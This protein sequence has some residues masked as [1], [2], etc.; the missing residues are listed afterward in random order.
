VRLPV[1]IYFCHFVYRQR[2]DY[3][4]PTYQ[5]TYYVQQGGQCY[6]LR[7][8]LQLPVDQVA[9][10][11]CH[12]ADTGAQP[13]Y[14]GTLPP[15][16]PPRPYVQQQQ[17]QHHQSGLSDRGFGRENVYGAPRM[18]PQR[19]L[20][21]L[22][23]I[24]EAATAEV[25]QQQ[26]Q[27]QRAGRPALQFQRSMPG[28]STAVDPHCPCNQPGRPAAGVQQRQMSQPTGSGAASTQSSSSRG[29]VISASD[30]STVLAR[31]R[32]P[33]L[34]C[35]VGSGGPS[36]HYT[37][38]DPTEVQHL[39]QSG[40]VPGAATVPGIASGVLQSSCSG[41]VYDPT[42]YGSSFQYQSSLDDVASC[43][44]PSSAGGGVV[45]GMAGGGGPI[46]GAGVAVGGVVSG[47]VSGSS[48]QLASGHEIPLRPARETSQPRLDSAAS[49]AAGSGCSENSSW[50]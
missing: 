43:G 49:C 5:P 39:L 36:Q 44:S 46:G 14:C 34:P 28:S 38:L 35:S 7:E 31:G 15:P 11:G 10:G 1:Y 22:P 33:S 40:G 48:G 37:V 13:K 30:A 41:S 16:K 6:E 42:G 21:S 9:F 45:V 19:P 8:E 27:Q 20:P 17:P 26:Q 29:T 24:P 2:R 3:A 47:G 12:G 23:N 18:D 50:P 25:S 4:P 32:I